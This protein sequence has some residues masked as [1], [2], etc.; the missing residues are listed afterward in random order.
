[1]SSVN[2]QGLRRFTVAGIPLI[3][4]TAKRSDKYVLLSKELVL[5]L[6]DLPFKGKLI[7]VGTFAIRG[8]GRRTVYA[9]PDK[10]IEAEG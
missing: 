3:T 4:A 9:I 1:M 5:R 2:S 8:Q 7:P 10:V 6:G